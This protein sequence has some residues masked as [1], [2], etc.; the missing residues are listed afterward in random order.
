ML[1][2]VCLNEIERNYNKA[3]IAY[4]AWADRIMVSHYYLVTICLYN[5]SLCAC[6]CYDGCSTRGFSIKAAHDLMF[7]TSLYKPPVCEVGRSVHGGES[8][9]GP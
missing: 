7:H 8:Q 2:S 5:V 1:P 6:M 4:L 3:I 9:V